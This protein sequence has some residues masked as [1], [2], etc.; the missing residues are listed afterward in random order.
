MDSEAADWE[1]SFTWL[2]KEGKASN[3]RH[4][5]RSIALSKPNDLSTGQPT[6]FRISADT[7]ARPFS[8]GRVPYDFAVEGCGLAPVSMEAQRDAA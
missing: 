5:V 1:T 6:Q 8:T 4:L 7:V 3:F 2:D